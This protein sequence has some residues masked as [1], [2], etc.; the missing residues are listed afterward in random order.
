MAA[1]I[2]LGDWNRLIHLPYFVLLAFHCEQ[3]A[4]YEKQLNGF[5]RQLT[6]LAQARLS[7][8][9]GQLLADALKE[10]ATVIAELKDL[11]PSA[12]TTGARQAIHAA[13]R[14][15]EG[16]TFQEYLSAMLRL[17]RSIET[18]LPLHA[19]FIGLVV[20]HRS[21]PIVDSIRTVLEE[22][23]DQRGKIEGRAASSA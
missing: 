21:T 10:G 20:R 18:S 11:N 15:L 17:H 2:G 5:I 8:V 19:R 16:T 7:T 13:R 3:G 4:L 14:A 6:E 23:I 12:M 1:A 22:A 9:Q